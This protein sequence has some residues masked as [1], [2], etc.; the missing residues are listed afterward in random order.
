MEIGPDSGK[1]LIVSSI[2]GATF[3][4]TGHR[5]LVGQNF[6]RDSESESNCASILAP[7]DSRRRIGRYVPSEWVGF[8]MTAEGGVSGRRLSAGARQP[9]CETVSDK[10]GRNASLGS[11][12]LLLIR[13]LETRRHRVSALALTLG[14]LTTTDG[15]WAFVSRRQD[16]Q[17]PAHAAPRGS[18]Q[19]G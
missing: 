17:L 5:P 15:H 8:M 4:L 16:G 7:R 6:L 13:P 11:I 1:W 12:A 3:D 2:C 14:S 10:P 9:G 19:P 18:K